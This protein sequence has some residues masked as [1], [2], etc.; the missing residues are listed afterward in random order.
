MIR[1]VVNIFLDFDRAS[2]VLSP[3][4]VERRFDQFQAT[5][6]KSLLN[7]SFKEFE[8]WVYCGLRNRALTERFPWHPRV[9]PTWDKGKEL[10]KSK[11]S[12]H[13]SLTRLDSDDLM[14]ETAMMQVREYAEQVV[15]KTPWAERSVLIFRKNLFWDRNS[16]YIGYHYRD[17]PPFF[18]HIFPAAIQGRPSRYEAL[19]FTTH[20]KSGA[21]LSTTTELGTHQVMVIKHKQNISD[22]RRNRPFGVC[23]P[24]KLQGLRER[25]AVIAEGEKVPPLLAHFGVQESDWS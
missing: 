10:I 1:Y 21:R 19:H 8:I 20:G 7:Q 16:G 23:S 15:A 11:P 25:G 6:L 4:W 18:T 17:S 9:S 13:L 14:R 12:D 24:E 2:L 5:T 3:E 22:I